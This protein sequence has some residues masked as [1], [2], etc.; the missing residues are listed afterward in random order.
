MKYSNSLTIKEV[1]CGFN[2]IFA[3]GDIHGCHTELKAL[4]EYMKEK[5]SLSESDLVVFLGDYIDRGPDS[6]GVID[7]LLQFRSDFPSTF[8]LKGNHEEMLLD[9]LGFDGCK[10]DLYLENGGVDTIA[11]YQI[12]PLIPSREVLKEFTNEHISCFLELI[13][14]VKVADW[15]FVHA[16]ID[17]QKEM[18]DQ[19]EVDLHWIRGEFIEN[20]HPFNFTVVFGHTP[21][22]EVL[23]D[24]PYKVGIDT[25]VVYGNSLSCLEV[26]TGELYQVKA[27]SKRVS[28]SS[29][30]PWK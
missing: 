12:N 30:R 17:P 5:L 26:T 4:L 18:I 1:P 24:L 19:T 9:Y 10:G 22:S 7:E 28:K 16:G 27:R 14:C 3:I 25:G 11:S 2:R 15:L 21:Q 13:D 20:T 6:K 29:L 23:L 8:F